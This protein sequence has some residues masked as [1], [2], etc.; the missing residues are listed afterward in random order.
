MEKDE[1]YELLSQYEGTASVELNKALDAT[2]SLLQEGYISE[3]LAKAIV[4]L[5]ISKHIHDEMVRDLYGARHKTSST[6][7]KLNF[8]NI[9]YGKTHE[10]YA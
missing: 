9:S 1:L 5:L 6:R 10:T 7:H 8:L 4:K 2:K 3:D